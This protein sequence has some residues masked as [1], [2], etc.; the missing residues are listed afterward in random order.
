MNRCSICGEV[1]G[2]ENPCDTCGEI[3]PP[4]GCPDCAYCGQF[5]ILEE[6]GE[7]NEQ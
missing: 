2:C 7:L 5:Y 4:C 3:I 1:G 6:V